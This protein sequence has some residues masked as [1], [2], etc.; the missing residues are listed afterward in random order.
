MA[1]NPETQPENPW[2][3]WVAMFLLMAA[4]FHIVAEAA[5]QWIF[6]PRSGISKYL[7]EFRD[8]A[9]KDGLT[10]AQYGR[11]AGLDGYLGWGKDEVRIHEPTANSAQPKTLLF[12]G[13]SVTA[14][15]DV[16]GGIEDYP[17]LLAGQLGGQGVRI[18]NLAAR[19]YGVDQMWLKLLTK[20]GEYHPDMIVMG[21]IPH[22]LI[23][24]A[25]DFNF[26]LPKPRF[27][28]TNT[29]AKLNLP[30]SVIDYMADYESARSWFHLSS[31]YVANY[32]AN[33]EYY[34]PPLF[35]Q[36]Y[37]RLY[38]HI[39]E[40]LAKL[41]EEWGIPIR[42]VKLTNYYHFKGSEMLVKL[43]TSEWVH[44]T[45][46]DKADVGFLDTDECVLKQAKPQSLDLAKEFAHHPGPA[47]H[48]LLAE[49]I[50][51]SIQSGL[52]LNQVG[53]EKIP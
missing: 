35:T 44:P 3:L 4:L 6:A 31:W 52:G 22:D 29:Q 30:K 12:V 5:V 42:V 32:W 16:R 24:P 47:G 2:K 8:K 40:G 50:G 27:Q 26:G 51:P 38:H 37:Q 17:A 18:V 45:V 19:G 28:F 13:D 9:Q 33:K 7:A 39:G 15:H 11:K 23:R 10:L 53:S 46:W 20:A 48:R 25:N 1:M 43:A 21:Y 41:S 36:Y 49:C 14:G 34:A